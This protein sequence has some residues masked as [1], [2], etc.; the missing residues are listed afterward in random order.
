MKLGMWTN[1]LNCEFKMQYELERWLIERE[2]DYVREFHLPDVG[3][4]PD[5]I[6]LNSPRVL[7]NIEA[8]CNNM[9]ELLNQM[10][11]N[12]RICKYSFAFIPDYCLT[13]FWFKE[14]LIKHG[15][16]LFIYNYK[17]EVITEALEAHYNSGYNKELHNNLI[18]KIKK[19]ILKRDHLKN[20]KQQ[21]FDL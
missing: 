16:G 18:P 6:I 7:I 5:F 2:I 14:E 21:K 17:K 8:K 9:R 11:D 15:F 3:R 19:A 12:A 4:R 1:G 20:I 13:P 10:I